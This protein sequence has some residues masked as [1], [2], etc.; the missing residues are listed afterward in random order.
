[1]HWEGVGSSHPFFHGAHNNLALRTCDYQRRRRRSLN[2]KPSQYLQSFFGLHREFIF[3]SNVWRTAFPIRDKS[4][5]ES[6]RVNEF[7][8]LL[9]M[10]NFI[11]SS[12]CFRLSGVCAE[13]SVKSLQFSVGSPFTDTTV[14]FGS[15]GVFDMLS[16]A[17]FRSVGKLI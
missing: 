7:L 6:Y 13:I 17:V 1:L 12:S 16:L 5:Y 11:V 3:P 2:S 15:A 10:V 14:E 9:V 8:V 4:L